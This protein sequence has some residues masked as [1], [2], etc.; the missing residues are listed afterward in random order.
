MTTA[1]RV[2]RGLALAAVLP[3]AQIWNAYLYASTRDGL[4]SKLAT[5]ATFV[6]LILLSAAVWALAWVV[7]LL[8][9]S[10]L[11]HLE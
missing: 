4:P 2:L 3:F 6:P 10:R 1:R 9:A 7:V 5:F 11:L 8:V